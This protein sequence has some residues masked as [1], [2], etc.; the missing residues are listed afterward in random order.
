MS[1]QSV[2]IYGPHACGKTTLAD[3]LREHLQLDFVVD[4]WDGHTQYPR[5]GALVLTSNP[6]AVLETGSPCMHFGA[7][8]RSLVSGARA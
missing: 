5:Q 8:V 3:D 4:D 6:D 1:R 7:A 2:V